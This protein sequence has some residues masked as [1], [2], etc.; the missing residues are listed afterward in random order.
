MPYVELEDGNRMWYMEKGGGTPLVFIHGWRGS[1]FGWEEPLDEKTKSTIDY[2]GQLYRTIAFDLLGHGKS[3]T[4]QGASYALPDLVAH[5]DYAIGKVIGDERFVLAGISMGGMVS[6]IYATTPEYAKRLKG[7]ILMST[8]P[9]LRTQRSK[10]TTSNLKSGEV[11]FTDRS[12]AAALVSA[13]YTSK[14]AKEHE[15]YVKKAIDHIMMSREEVGAKTW[16]SMGNDVA[17][18]NKLGS[19]KVPTLILA[20]DKD[21][22]I[23]PENSKL[24]HEKIKNSELKILGPDVG[25]SLKEA[26][27][28]LHREILNFLRKIG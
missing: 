22:L 21:K 28:Q 10:T 8:T 6:L 14:F 18:V 23:M 3:D 16:D 7:L 27:D 25:H 4:P 1:T 26:Q 24:M 13:S 17:V 9:G 20:G 5:L 12:L 19:I 11:K 2:F 15:D